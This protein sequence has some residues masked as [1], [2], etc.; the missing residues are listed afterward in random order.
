MREFGRFALAFA[1]LMTLSARAQKSPTTKPRQKAA[2]SPWVEQTLKKMTLREKLGQ[3]IMVYYFGVFTST[4]SPDY[5]EMLHE[6]DD[7]HVGGII[8][9]TI[10]GPLG[11]ERG[12]VYPTAVITNEFQRRAT[13]PLFVGADFESGAGQRIDEGTNL[14]AAMAIGATGDPRLA[15]EAGKVTAR[16]ARA[17]GVTWVFAP[18]ADVN[19]NP[20][21]PII[22]IRSFG[23]DPQSVAAYVSNFV[24]GIQENGA[25][26][27]AKHFPGHGDVSVDSHLTLAVV[28]G[29]RN[30]L[31]SVELV[32]FRAAI[33]AGVGSIMPGHLSVPAFEPDPDVPATLSKNILTGLLRDE[34]KFRGLIVTDAMDMGGVT[35]LYPPGEA[36]ARAV[37][38]GADVLLM[39]PVPDA[40]M[41]G[42]EDAVAS[43]R[44]SVKQIDASVRRILEAKA[45]LGL[46]KKRFVDVPRI[47]STFALPEYQNEAQSIADRGVTLLRDSQKLV[48][49][50]S[51][52]PMRVLL[53]SLSADPDPYPGE[54]L[55][56][57]IRW[58]VDSLKALR[59]DTQYFGVSQL[60]LP[61]PDT[62][63]VAIAALFVRVADR[64][65]NVGFPDDERALVGQLLAAGKPTAV[66]AFGSPYLIERFPDAKT[67]IAEF[68]TN[69]V[70][71]RAAAR[72][73]FGQVPFLGKIPVTVPGTVKRGDGLRTE[74]N[75][76]T[77]Q[78]AS[79]SMADRLKPV[80]AVLDQALADDAFPGGVVA[81][82]WHGE[83]AVHPFGHLTR[84]AKSPAVTANTIYDMASVTKVVVTTTSLMMLVQ[85]KRLDLDAPVSRYLPEFATAAKS[86]PNPAWRARIT[87][88]NLM[89]HDSG[90]P[91]IRQFFK[92]TKGYDAI[93]HRAV[94]EPLVHEPGTQ[95]EYSDLGFMLLG[96]IVQR[97][98]GE[99]LDT[100]AKEHIFE[101]LGMNDSRFNPS[102]NL[103]SR[104]APTELDAAYRKRLIVGEVHDENSWAMGGVAGH[105]GLFSTARDIA[106]FAQVMLNGGIYAYHRILNRSTI[107]QFTGREDI[108]NSARALGW[109]VVTQPSSAGHDFS[110]GSFG[111]TGF[112]GTSVWIDPAR[113]LFVVLLTNRVNPTR[114]N[115]KIRQVRPAVH[116]A[117]FQALGLAPAPATGR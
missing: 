10:R 114:A 40:A 91:G 72:A 90:L 112:T 51:T 17:A 58:R 98:T 20:D 9:G 34:L 24:R 109:D 117:V 7:N 87:I 76:M 75:L 80:Y 33:S 97:L 6:V 44:I 12:Q 84:D 99:R 50:D 71:Q 88:R 65:G 35:T 107:Q 36:A 100:F 62:Y 68:S 13:V 30:E 93:I 32:P 25:L 92:D 53:V 14:P 69:D 101:P 89:L 116:D 29:D 70:A 5:K 15:Y 45:R 82:G 8:L 103:R 113:D 73:L 48:P 59:A 81:V 78:P 43:G 11:I 95:V 94:S 115:E 104:I 47:N 19:N 85:Q 108:E 21:N 111:H 55:E 26:A 16:E 64:K 46:D 77:L 86:D 102:R 57:E 110:P 1:L 61:P 56:P 41:K 49:L 2:S 52:K 96:E 3:M 67:F 39:P 37:E 4:K 28:P 79:S 63:D 23:E 42:L 83:V 27:T 66:V 105:A 60:K 22:N 31:E 74:A 18:V 38:A 54:T 106:A